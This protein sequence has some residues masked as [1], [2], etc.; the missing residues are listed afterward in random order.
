MNQSTSAFVSTRPGI[1]IDGEL[2]DDL[3]EALLAMV[4]NLPLHGSAHAELQ[5][6]NWG[7]REGEREP[8]Y[9][10]SEIML[11]A[12]VEVLIEDGSSP[13]QS[14]SLF[15]GE[16][17]A[18]EEKYGEGA[19]LIVLLLQDKLHHLARN[20]HN[21][22]FEDQSPDD[23]VQSIASAAGLQA[24]AAIS[25]LTT[26]W[27]Q[28]NESDLAFLVR[29]GNRFDIGIRLEDNRLRARAE[30]ADPDPI[31]L[32]IQDSALKVRLITDLNH[33]PIVSQVDGYNLANADTASFRS[34]SMTPVPA[35][36]TAAATLNDLGWQGEEIVPQ[37]F[38][39][40]NAEAEAYAKAAFR[41][42]AKRFIQGEIIC[43]G[44]A[45]LK[46]GREIELSDVSPRLRGTYQ[47]VHC[48]HRF[49]NNVG[50]ET[51]LKVN[52]GGWQP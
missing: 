14:Q 19:P 44:E 38:P 2:R 25:S 49:D 37:P 5:F 24:D 8:S 20:R 11:G 34:E 7:R 32:N 43:Q 45:S 16:I 23:L 26:T 21:R 47:V 50:F 1:K 17:T 52:K 27:H 46:P 22:S 12:A 9:I 28:L 31:T 4:V 6:S 33:Q 39:G 51:H 3:Q 36:T 15:K 40:S 48:V 30:E 18:I 35:G 29:V 10:L 42:Q 13:G 41:R